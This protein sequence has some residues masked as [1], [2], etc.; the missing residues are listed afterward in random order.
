RDRAELALLLRDDFPTV[1]A[2]GEE[3]AELARQRLVEAPP[4]L[5]ADATRRKGVEQPAR[6]PAREALEGGIVA[7]R[8]Y[9][10]FLG[11]SGRDSIGPWSESRSMGVAARR[12]AYSAPR[13]GG[14]AA[15]RKQRMYVRGS[16][17]ALNARMS[18]RCRQGR[19]G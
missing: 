10:V 3:H 19:S 6:G 16:A 4:H 14:M 8:D 9:M 17:R 15:S 2:T 18:T 7:H 12:A 1:E 11:S 5:V 13:A